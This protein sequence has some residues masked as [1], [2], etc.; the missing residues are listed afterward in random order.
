M[1]IKLARM[2]CTILL[3]W[4]IC[5]TPYAAMHGYVMFFNAEGMSPITGLLPTMI[6]KFSSFSNSMLYGLRYYEIT[7][8]V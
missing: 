7:G 5:W 2:A 1:E 8:Y 3:L 4:I 6:T